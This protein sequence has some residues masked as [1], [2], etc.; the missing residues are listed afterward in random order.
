M[1]MSNQSFINEI[2]ISAVK[3]QK[4]YH[5][6]PSLIIAQ[7]CLESG[8]GKSTLAAKGNN[9]FGVK[10]TYNG[11]FLEMETKEWDKLN[12][13]Y[14]VKAK[15]RK[16]P[17]WEESLEDHALLFVHGLK[18]EKFNRY[19]AVIGEPNYKEA[20]QAVKKAGYATD[21]DYPILLNKLI[22]QYNL[23]RFDKST[24]QTDSTS[25]ITEYTVKPG[26]TLSKIAYQH[27]TTV[28]QIVHTNQLKNPDLILPGQTLLLSSS[29]KYYQIKKG[30]TISD[31]ASRFRSTVSTIVSLNKLEN[32]DRIYPGQ[33]IR[34]K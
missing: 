32:P 6:L 11:D 25:S 14:S 22:E 7:A 34:I 8:Y 20:T 27:E 1:F 13:W 2:A 3:L 5:I 33:K 29:A 28:Q 31:I 18:R 16:Y 4:K 30:D 9:L 15:F 10:G 12:G 23:T 17:S 21:P 26:D 19:A 24:H